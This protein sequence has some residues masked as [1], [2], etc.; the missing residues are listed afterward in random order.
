MY[1]LIIIQPSVDSW[2][3][4][5]HSYLFA[6][7]IINIQNSHTLMHYTKENTNIHHTNM[8][9]NHELEFL[10]KLDSSLFG[11]FLLV[12]GSANKLYNARINK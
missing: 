2:L 7:G 12:F 8:K 5:T 3:T 10:K 1:I 4:T 11:F 6:F 9:S